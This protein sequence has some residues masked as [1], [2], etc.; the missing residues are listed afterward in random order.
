V[1]AGFHQRLAAGNAD[2]GAHVVVHV[3]QRATRPRG[4]AH[5][6]EDGEQRRETA[7]AGALLRYLGKDSSGLSS[8]LTMPAPS[9]KALNIGYLPEESLPQALL[10]AAGARSKAR[11]IAAPSPPP[12]R[13]G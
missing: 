2:I 10:A 7:A 3:D 5:G 8:R 4:L 12:W 13:P 11:P 1:A 9:A 6:T